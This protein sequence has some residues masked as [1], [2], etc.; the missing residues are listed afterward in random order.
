VPK[1]ERW[2]IASRMAEVLDR[3]TLKGVLEFGGQVGGGWCEVHQHICVN[4]NNKEQIER[5]LQN[6]G[7]KISYMSD[8]RVVHP[9]RQHEY[10]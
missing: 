9:E 6:A 4:Q 7:Y 10:M 3:D 5:L 8:H 1:L 2:I